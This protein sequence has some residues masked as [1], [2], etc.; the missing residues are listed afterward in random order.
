[1]ANLH[2]LYST[3]KSKIKDGVWVDFGE[4]TGFLI[5]YAGKSNPKYAAALT[6]FLKP[7][8]HLLKRDALSDDEAEQ[9]EFDLFFHGILRD[10]RG[11]SDE[12]GNLLDFGYENAKALFRKLPELMADLNRFAEEFANYREETESSA[13]N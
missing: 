11:V 5:A 1:M 12:D 4:E 6:R 10:W 9:L 2:K 7:K 8:Q 3:N 13:K